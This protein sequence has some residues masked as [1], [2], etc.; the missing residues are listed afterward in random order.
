MSGPTTTDAPPTSRRGARCLVAALAFTLAGVPAAWSQSA[1]S[2]DSGVGYP[3]ITVPLSVRLVLTES[4][5]AAQFDVTYA[6][7]RVRALEVLRAGLPPHWLLRTNEVAPGVLRV[8]IYSLDNL[9]LPRGGPVIRVPFAVAPTEHVG[10]G[11]ITPARLVLA[12]LD[13]GAVALVAGVPGFIHIRPVHRRTNGV[14]DFFFASE[15]GVRYSIQAT[16]NF[17]HWVGLTNLTAPADFMDLVDPD[18]PHF[19]YR[20]YRWVR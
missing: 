1:I 13:A 2:V 8:V 14:V 7:A 5:V 20:F 9:P 3:G 4:A 17:S 11:P 12:R 19:P 15:P 18:A 10:S 6:P 16:T